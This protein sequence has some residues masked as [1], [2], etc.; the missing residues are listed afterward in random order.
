[1]KGLKGYLKEAVAINADHVAGEGASKFA[2][3]G[4]PFTEGGPFY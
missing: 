1:M 4:G 2:S 3:R